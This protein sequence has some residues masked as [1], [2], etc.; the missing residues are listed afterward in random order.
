V[1]AAELG[2]DATLGPALLARARNAIART[3]GEAPL[4]EPPHPALHAPGATF[5]T[6]RRSGALRGCIGTLRAERPLDEDVRL[7]ARAAAFD[8]PRFAPLARAEYD[9][10]EIEVSLLGE[11]EPLAAGSEAQALALLRRGRDGVILEWRGRRATFLPQ[12]WEQLPQ[13]ARFLAELRR[14]AGLA[15][16]FWAPD[17]RLARYEVRQF[18]QAS[19]IRAA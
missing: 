5:V 6:L 10:L 1:S 13:A 2:A 19:S 17:L 7:H 11:A 4:P 9:G 16:D 3:W 8:D 18:A 14:K 15:A 12:V